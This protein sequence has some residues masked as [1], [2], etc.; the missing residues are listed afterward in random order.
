MTETFLF[1]RVEPQ[2]ERPTDRS[3]NWGSCSMPKMKRGRIEKKLVKSAK[4]GAEDGT[5]QAVYWLA[6]GAV[7]TA[8]G[9]AWN[10]T[11]SRKS[12]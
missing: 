6:F 9:A 3:E 8:F 7:L 2:S 12:M 10:W 1:G 11:R 5:N 4:A